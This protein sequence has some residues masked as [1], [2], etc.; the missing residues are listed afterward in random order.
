MT[1]T[2][3]FTPLEELIRFQLGLNAFILI[4]FFLLV[5]VLVFKLYYSH[6]FKWGN[7]FSYVLFTLIS[8]TII[9]NVF[10]SIQMQTDLYYNLQ[11]Y[12]EIHNQIK[13]SSN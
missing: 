13:K 12:I 4:L 9:Y 10:Y 3:I 6:N 11:D 1:K 2:P 5:L 7:I 8:L